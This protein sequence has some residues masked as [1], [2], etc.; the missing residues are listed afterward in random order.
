MS[1]NAFARYYDELTRNVDYPARAAA[2][3]TLVRSYGGKSGGILL[4]LAC[5]TGSLS[6][7]LARLGYDVIG[8]DS[9]EE[10]LGAAFEKKLESG[11]PIQ[12]LRQDMRSL[13]M[14]GT[15]DVTVCMLDSLNHLPSRGDV[16]RT[17]ERVSL[18]SEPDGLFIFD[19][20]TRYKHEHVLADNAYIFDTP[21]VFCAWQNSFC[22]E[23][24]EVRINLDFF[25]KTGGM[26]KRYSESFSEFA[27]SDAEMKQMLSAAGFTLLDEIDFDSGES[28]S[29]ISQKVIYICRKA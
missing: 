11:L 14:F 12:F 24:C 7:E 27:Y 19:V 17:F 22:P 23:R 6:V 20:N 13:D 2:I 16:E 28:P 3:D 5:G 26:Y 25:E 1:Y 18:F 21:S 10:M 8:V 29:D 15:I 4:D 9:S